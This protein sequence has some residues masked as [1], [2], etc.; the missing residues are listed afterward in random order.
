MARRDAAFTAAATALVVAGLVLGFYQLGGRPRQRDLRADQVRVDHLREIVVEVRNEWSARAGDAERKLPAT[1]A[2]MSVRLGDRS[3]QD[4]ITGAPYEYM[5]QSGSQYELCAVFAA[6]SSAQ[7]PAPG[8]PWKHPQGRHCF[9]FDAASD[10][11]EL[12]RY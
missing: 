1:L 10:S 4:P 3:I 12:F 5:P 2:D 7:Q 6:E 11:Q 8:S 9:S